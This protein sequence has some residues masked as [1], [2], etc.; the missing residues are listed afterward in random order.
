VNVLAVT[1]TSFMT[2]PHG[3][4]SLR[5]MVT[6][7]HGHFVP[8]HFVPSVGITDLYIIDLH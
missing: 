3:L 7:F 6:S 2:D 8:G 1:V 5:S 4:Q